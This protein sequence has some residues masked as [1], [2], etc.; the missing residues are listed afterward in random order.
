M[1]P[2]HHFAYIYIATASIFLA[3]RADDPS[4]VTKDNP[5][6]KTWT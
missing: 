2:H 5:I 1:F 3:A 6:Y 4:R